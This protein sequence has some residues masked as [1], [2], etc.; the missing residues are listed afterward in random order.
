MNKEEE[1]LVL[2]LLC[3]LLSELVVISCGCTIL[4][5]PTLTVFAAASD[6]CARLV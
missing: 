2:V 1:K 6:R 5:T 3:A 4:Q